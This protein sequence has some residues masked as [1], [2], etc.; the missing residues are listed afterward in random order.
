[1]LILVYKNTSYL[2]NNNKSMVNIIT[3]TFKREVFLDYP[4][5][6][7]KART[8]PSTKKNEGAIFFLKFY[9]EDEEKVKSNHLML[10][11]ILLYGEEITKEEYFN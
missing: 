3:E 10:N 5:E 9:G 11:E 1:M 8:I 2:K 4:F 6:K 7:V